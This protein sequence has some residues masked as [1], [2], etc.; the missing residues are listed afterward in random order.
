MNK[1]DELF[2]A[3]AIIGE[4]SYVFVCDVKND[5]SRWSKSAVDYFDLPDEY[6]KNAGGIWAEHIHPEDRDNFALHPAA[7]SSLTTSAPSLPGIR[8]VTTASIT[9]VKGSSRSTIAKRSAEFTAAM[10]KGFITWSRKEK[11]NRLLAT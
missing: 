3:F 9:S 5:I 2:D 6:M 1:L 10:E 4:G 8:T 11:W 7:F